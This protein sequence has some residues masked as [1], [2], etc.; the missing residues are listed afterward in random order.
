M[1]WIL[2]IICI[3]HSWQSLLLGEPKKLVPFCSHLWE[4][5]KKCIYSSGQDIPFWSS[6]ALNLFELKENCLYIWLTVICVLS[7]SP[8]QL[9]T[10]SLDTVSELLHVHWFLVIVDWHDCIMYKIKIVLF[11]LRFVIIAELTAGNVKANVGACSERIWFIL[12]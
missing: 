5:N 10:E 2:V 12:Y 9:S 4:V 6:L 1:N 7:E 3:V 11:N 8:P